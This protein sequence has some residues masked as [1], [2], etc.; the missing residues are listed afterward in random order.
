MNEKLMKN[1]RGG[2]YV[3][4]MGEMWYSTTNAHNVV[5]TREPGE[6]RVFAESELDEANRVLEYECPQGCELV[7]APKS[8]LD[9]LAPKPRIPVDPL[10]PN[11][12]SPAQVSR[13]ANHRKRVPLVAIGNRG[14][15]T[16][17]KGRPL[18]DELADSVH[19]LDEQEA[20]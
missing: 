9:A 16:D 4:Q 5:A 19:E 20:A 2:H 10:R 8:L 7:P 14:Y 11:T 15:E 13:K 1:L 17:A 3:I 12:V 6:I 18:D